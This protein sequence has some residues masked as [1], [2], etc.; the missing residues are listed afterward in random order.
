MKTATILTTALFTL[1][2][3]ANASAHRPPHPHHQNPTVVVIKPGKKHH[4]QYTNQFQSRG[5]RQYLEL[6]RMA[7]ADGVLTPRER[8]ILQ[9]NRAVLR[10]Q[11]R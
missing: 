3:S 1:I 4:F 8:I 10:E 2:I 6:K 7:L 11:C 5:Q 9:Q